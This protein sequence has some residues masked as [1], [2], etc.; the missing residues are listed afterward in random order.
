LQKQTLDIA[1]KLLESIVE[2][3]VQLSENH[4]KEI[5]VVGMKNFGASTPEE[6]IIKFAK[7]KLEN[8][9]K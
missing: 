8:T 7:R 3:Q 6:Y 2:G 5:P 4:R 9:K 1:V